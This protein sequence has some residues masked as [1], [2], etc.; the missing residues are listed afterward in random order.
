MKKV[1]SLAV[2]F[3]V[4]FGAVSCS[5]PKYTGVWL[6]FMVEDADGKQYSMPDYFTG[7]EEE[8]T[9]IMSIRDDGTYICSSFIG[10]KLLENE[11]GTYTV[12]DGKIDFN[13]TKTYTGQ[14]VNG[15]LAIR[16]DKVTLY[17]GKT[18]EYKT[19]NGVNV[20]TSAVK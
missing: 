16:Y 17:F 1:I 5:A 14:M 19:N 15:Y 10:T 4:L 9:V 6:A 12:H 20:Q 7:F 3:V 18:S 13:E 8:Y 11:K 2:I